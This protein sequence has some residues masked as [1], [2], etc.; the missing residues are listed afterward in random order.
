M[1]CCF[2]EKRLPFNLFSQ[3]LLTSLSKH[4]EKRSSLSK[5]LSVESREINWTVGLENSKIV[6]W[7]WRSEEIDL[8]FSLTKITRCYGYTWKTLAF[9]LGIIDGLA[10]PY[11]VSMICL[12]S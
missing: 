1:T 7:I 5:L 10:F 11:R 3:K 12:T 2:Q 9:L 6:T 8:L 4:R